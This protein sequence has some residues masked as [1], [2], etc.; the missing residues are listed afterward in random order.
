[1]DEVRITSMNVSRAPVTMERAKSRL[2]VSGIVIIRRPPTYRCGCTDMTRFV[3]GES[4][5]RSVKPSSSVEGVL[6]SSLGS[7]LFYVLC[8]RIGR[9]LSAR[10]VAF[11]V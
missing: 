10:L 1:M 5:A 3:V 7:M 4:R 9:V 11:M 8:S 2:D 6:T